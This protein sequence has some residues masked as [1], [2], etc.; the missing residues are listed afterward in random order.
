ML[1]IGIAL[2]SLGSSSA[3]GSKVLVKADGTVFTTADGR[4]LVRI[5]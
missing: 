2:T 3:A 4:V 5:A 1:G